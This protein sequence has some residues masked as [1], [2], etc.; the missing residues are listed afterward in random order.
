MEFSVLKSKSGHAE[1]KKTAIAG[2]FLESCVG[3]R[4]AAA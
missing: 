2:G 1:N 3:V 4:T